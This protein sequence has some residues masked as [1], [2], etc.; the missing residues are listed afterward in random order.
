MLGRCIAGPWWLSLALLLAVLG[1][2]GQHGSGVH[3]VPLNQKAVTVNQP[4]TLSVPASI[5]VAEDGKVPIAGIAVADPDVENDFDGMLKL[6]LSASK[7]TLSLGAVTGLSFLVGD[8]A[9]DSILSFTGGLSHLQ[10]ALRS[11]E[12]A[13]KAQFSGVDVVNVLVDD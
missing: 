4:P 12:Y 6:T 10:A 7:G 2:A 13:P 11:L 9:A 1:P 5:A 3:A 8:G